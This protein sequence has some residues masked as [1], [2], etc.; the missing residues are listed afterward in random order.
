M[1]FDFA[2]GAGAGDTVIQTLVNNGYSF[3]N[4]QALR[5]PTTTTEGLLKDY[6][7]GDAIV[8][9]LVGL[10]KKRDR[11]MARLTLFYT[12]QDR[13]VCPRTLEVVFVPSDSGW[14]LTSKKV[15]G[16]C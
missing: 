5:R 1:H 8:L 4:H 12:E 14:A 13:R 6:L 10:L 15:I 11:A 3:G 9:N 2:F 7:E 16:D